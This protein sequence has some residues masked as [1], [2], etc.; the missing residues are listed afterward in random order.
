MVHVC[1]NKVHVV[2]DC[3]YSVHIDASI[4]ETEPSL[5]LVT[6]L[7]TSITKDELGTVSIVDRVL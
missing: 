7:N 4:T 6:N 2:K 1:Y 3:Q 5:D